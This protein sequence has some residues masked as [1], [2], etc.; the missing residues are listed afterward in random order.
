MGRSSYGVF[1][2][3][4]CLRRSWPLPIFGK[5]H[6]YSRLY[7]KFHHSILDWI[8]CYNKSLF[9]IRAKTFRICKFSMK[10]ISSFIAE[11]GKQPYP[12]YMC[13]GSARCFPRSR[14]C[15]PF[16][17]CPDATEID[18]LFCANKARTSYFGL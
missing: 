3:G 10:F 12:M 2:I 15:S 6:R 7:S 17:R 16:S 14:V 1:V 18:K 4:A 13:S 8:S 9:F 11:C 5:Y